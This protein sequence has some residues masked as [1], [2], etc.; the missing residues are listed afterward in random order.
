MSRKQK[1]DVLGFKVSNLGRVRSADIQ[2]APLTILVGK[3]DTGKS[4]VA[5]LIWALSNLS[6]LVGS[7]DGKNRR[8]RW[9]REFFD[10]GEPSIDKRLTID[11][12]K[13][14]E[15]VR[16]LNELL[17]KQGR[18]F[19]SR[20]FAFDGFGQSSVVVEQREFPPFELRLSVVQ[21]KG[22][23]GSDLD[24]VQCRIIGPDD[25]PLLNMTFA[26]RFL[27]DSTFFQDLVFQEIIY[28]VISGFGPPFGRM[29]Y[30]PA[31]RTGL[32]LSLNSLTSERF[33]Y[34]EGPKLDLPL[35]L[36][37]FLQN[38]SD[39]PLGFERRSK[40]KISRWLQDSVING[41]IVLDRKSV[42]KTFSF[43]PANSELEL[44]LHATSS[45]I[46]ELAPYLI[47][48]RSE[49][50]GRHFILE[51]PEA[52]LHLEAQREMARAMSRLI[53]AGA[54]VTLTTHSDTFLQQINN[55]MSLHAHPKRKALMKEFGYEKDDI[56]DPDS[57]EAYEFSC[58][59]GSTEVRRLKKTPEG[60][61]VPSLNN[62][63]L[64]LARETLAIREKQKNA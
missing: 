31:A 46:T 32:M 45:M 27:K 44:P 16:Y 30:I 17:R 60:F 33:R 28:N 8:P 21:E 47:S 34:N 12:E 42:T 10:L 29:T 4:Y 19:L 63:L 37:S 55:L 20:V 62:T 26:L 59:E 5:T 41:D 43:R 24:Q 54:Q 53:A 25:E 18:Q 58:D 14:S 15:L 9:I 51:E 7:A 38:I 56:L 6:F 1:N 52:H 3:N 13:G 39:P 57:V 49:V 2:L 48:L 35:P 23:D 22:S 11:S 61:V 64:A 50:R 36:S 40:T